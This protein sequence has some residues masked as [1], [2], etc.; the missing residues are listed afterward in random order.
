MSKAEELAKALNGIA[1]MGNQDWGRLSEAAAHLRAL[2][3]SHQRLQQALGNAI[4]RQ[5]YAP[6]SGP[7]W[8]E[9]ARSALEQA[10]ELT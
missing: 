10:K 7:V 1:V 8:W 4:A 3:A 6:G 9:N 2:E 5:A